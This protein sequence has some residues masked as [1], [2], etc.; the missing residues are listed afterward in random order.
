M[1]DWKAIDE[2]K[3]QLDDLR[4]FPQNTLKSL[5]EKI[6]LEWTYHSN[7]IEGNTLTLKET[8]VVLEGITIGGKSV[9]EHLEVINHH[10]AIQYLNEI[11][12]NKE[13]ISEWQI[14]QIH[15]LVLKKIDQAGAGVYRKE[16][17]LIS[18]AE[19][20]PPDY[21]HVPNEMKNLIKCYQEQ[22]NSLHPT[23]RAALLHIDFVKIHPF[24]DGNGRTSRLLQNFE[25]MKEG[26]PP[27]VIKKENRLKYYNALDEAHTTGKPQDFIK[28]SAECLNESLNLYLETIKKE[29]NIK[30]FSSRKSIK[31]SKTSKEK[32]VTS[33]RLINLYK[34]WRS[35]QPL[36]EENN[37]A[38]WQWIRLQFNHHSNQFEG[39]T[40][41][42][43]ETQLLLIHGRA[44]GDH[45]I[46]EY[47]E[48]KAHNVAFNYICE[49]AGKEKL[50]DEADIR[51][52]NKICLKEPFYKKVRTPDGQSIM[53]KITPGKYKNQP[54]HVMTQTGEIFHF[55]SPEETPAK[56][57]ELVKWIQNW[58]KKNKAEQ[59]KYLVSFLAELHQ[60]FIRIHPF[61]DG[62]GRV[63]RLLLAYVLVRLNFLPM[64]LNNKEEYIKAIQFADAGNISHLKNL[65]LNN[66]ITML[67]K[68][69]Y[70]KNNKMDL[71]QKMEK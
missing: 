6:A 17:V 1:F 12:Q 56:M 2:K 34:K 10:E 65:F 7:A 14:R 42:Y 46:R 21:I 39:N 32:T 61:D 69:I 45:T 22:W 31:K 57:E 30:N 68:G 8:K 52:L 23:E 53:R 47:E 62:N 13:N 20:T 25:L 54:N 43:D 71:N 28:F 29:N 50:I 16:N 59:H 26:F 58:L 5:Q 38:L 48:M 3:A 27:I 66:I 41:V 55:A 9:K 63:V 33:L 40:L 60:R 49:L 67:E 37:Q 64:I 70:S 4:P 44:V 51:D 11:I 18:G 35:T 15:S 19:H 36:P 24:V